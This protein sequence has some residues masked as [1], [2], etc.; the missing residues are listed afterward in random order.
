MA[1]LTL[2]EFKA[3]SIMFPAD[4]D[5][6]ETLRPGYTDT[7]IAV[8]Q[9]VIDSRLR[10]RYAA[11]FA[12][13]VPEIVLGWLVSFVTHDA[14]RARGVNPEDPTIVMMTDDKTLAD[15]QMKEAA[16]SD[17]GLFDLPLRQDLQNSAVAFGG[18]MGYSETSP[19]V[20]AD[21]QASIGRGED[22]SGGGSY[23]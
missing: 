7:R 6:L 2:A 11:P 14:Q 13:P 10:K 23:S 3:R 15:T 18:P 9:S 17:T 19:Y 5:A 8:W 4:V 21:R 16:D 22:S 12:S 20:S 1:Y